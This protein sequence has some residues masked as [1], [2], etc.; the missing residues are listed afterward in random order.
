MKNQSSSAV[1][2]MS[3]SVRFCAKKKVKPSQSVQFDYLGPLVQ[4]HL[5]HEAVREALGCFV[6]VM[7]EI[8]LSLFLP[9]ISLKNAQEW[10][11]DARE[12]V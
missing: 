3:S 5:R 8:H 6:C 11:A 4:G 12:R 10:H 2:D 1:P 9:N 7:T